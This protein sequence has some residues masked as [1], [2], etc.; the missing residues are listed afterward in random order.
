MCQPQIMADLDR[1]Q[2]A[3]G[4]GFMLFRSGDRIYTGHTGG[5]PGHITG[6]F[7]HRPS[8]TSGLAMMNSGSAPDPATLSVALANAVIDHDPEE[9]QIWKPGREVPPE[10]EGVVGRWYSE[11]SPFV[12][13]VRDGHLEARLADAPAHKPSSVFTKIG[14]DCYRTTSGRETG[15]MLRITRDEDGTVL[16]M[17]WA[18]YPFTRKPLAFGE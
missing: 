17:N 4:L 2:L 3:F 10:L 1:W 12:F 13:F 18:T 7:T 9:P 16:K 14:D 6:L 5:M 8:G 11:G 15:E